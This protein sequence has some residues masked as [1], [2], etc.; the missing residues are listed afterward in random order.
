LR[1]IAEVFA[2]NNSEQA[3]V[4]SFIKVWSKVMELD[5]FE[6]KT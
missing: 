3:F 2:T 5:R 1:A 6:L 4:D